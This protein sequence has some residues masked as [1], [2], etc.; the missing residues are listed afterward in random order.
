VVVVAIEANPIQTD[1]LGEL[2]LPYDPEAGTP[3]PCLI[4]NE[5]LAV[6]RMTVRKL[7]T[8]VPDPVAAEKIET[9]D[10]RMAEYAELRSE[11]QRMVAGAKAKNAVAFGR[12]LVEGLRGEHDWIVPPITLYH[13]DRLDAVQF[14]NQMQALLLPEGE[15][16]TAI[17]GETQRIAWQYAANEDGMR[18]QVLDQRIAVVIHHGI[19]V[20]AARQGFYDLNVLEV[21]PNAAVAIGMDSRDPATA[22]TRTVI[23]ATDLKVNLRRRQLRKSDPELMTISALRQG[24]V[25]TILGEPGFQV[26]ARPVQLDPDIDLDELRD[27]VVEVWTAMLEM[28]EE[29]L[30]PDRRGDTVLSG[31]AF[32]AAVGVIAHHAMPDGVRDPDTE[33]WPVE[34]VVEHLDGVI[35]DR[36]LADGTFP[37][38]GIGGKRVEGERDGVPYER[39][40]LGGPKEVGYQIARALEN[41][42]SPEGRRIRH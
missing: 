2:P 19:A 15:F 40:S 26:G 7:L 9:S 10:P 16:L 8:Y 34:D 27:A 35:W 17:D 24:V 18:K 6:A 37:W 12:Y 23:D 25:C 36:K 42:H 33:G 1:G 3:I 32:I 41:A 20:R 11:V 5:H 4:I 29:H 14:A 38:E 22:I 28:L 39:F 13:Q 30:Q 31:P 21:K